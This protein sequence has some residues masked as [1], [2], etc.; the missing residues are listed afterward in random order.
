MRKKLLVLLLCCLGLFGIASGSAVWW[1]SRYLRTPEFRHELAQLVEEATGRT[2]RLDG[3]LSLSFFPWFGLK[4]K[5]FSLGNDPRFG[6]TPLLTASGISARIRVLPLLQRRLVF[7]TVELDNASIVLTMD[8]EGRGNW[9]GLAEHLRKQEDAQEKVGDFFRRITVRGL[10]L[11]DGN[12]RLDDHAHNHSYITTDVDLRTGR[13]ESGKALPFTVSLD[14]YWPRP[15]LTARLNGSGKLHWSAADPGPLLT[16]TAVQAEVGGVFMPKTA[17]RAGLSTVLSVEGGGKHL[18]LSETR[19]RILGYDVEGEI[20]FLDVTEMFHLEA[21]LQLGRFSPRSVLNAYWPGTIAHDYQGALNTASGPLNISADVNKLVFETPGFSL[22]NSQL[23]GFARMGFDNGTGL[24]FDIAANQ[25]DADALISAFT[26]NATSPPLVVAD[27]PLDYLRAVHGAGHIKAESLKLAGVAAQGAQVEWRGA[28][29]VHKAQIKPVKA[30]GGS[31][32]AELSAVFGEGPRDPRLLS[33]AGAPVLGWSGSLSMLGVDARQVSWLNKP[34]LATSGRMDLRA[35][36]EAKPVQAALTATLPH[37]VRRAVADVQVSLASSVLDWSA[38]VTAGKAQ[39]KGASAGQSASQAANQAASSPKR[40]FFS[41]LQAQA[42]FTPA[43]VADADWAL[44]MDAGLSAVGTK[45]LLNLDGRVSGL[46]RGQKGGKVLLTGAN[47]SGRLKG[48]FLPK[49][50]NEASFNGRGALDFSAQTLNLSSASVQ[51]CGVNVG[52]AVNGTKV[53]GADWALAGRLRCQDG[54]PKRVLAALDLRVP[55]AS[56][57]R[58]LQRL[59]GEGDL[60]LSGKGAS[61]ANFS[62]QLDDMPLRG[63]YAVQNFDAP[64]QSVTV[65]GGNF[66]LDRYLPAPEVPKRGAPPTPPTPEALPVDALRDLNL[67]GSVALRSFKYRGVTTRDFRATARAGGGQLLLKPFGGNFY[68]GT[69]TGEFSAQVQGNAMQ[70]RLAVAIKDYQAGPFM[71]GW[72]GKELVTGKADLFLDVTGTGAT[73]LEV[74]RTLEGLGSIKITDGA[75]Y[76]SGAAE[77]PQPQS[78]APQPRRSGAASMQQGQQQSQQPGQAPGPLPGHKPGSPFNLASAKLRVSQG[79]FRSD[80]FRLDA[81]TMAVTGKGRFSPAEDQINVNLAVNMTGMPVV[82]IKVFGRLKD[83]EMEI[84]T[85]TLISNT[86]KSLL[87]I[88]LKPIKFFKDLLF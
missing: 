6:E 33:G 14:F 66:D 72:T 23:K 86:I 57:R 47:A 19:L 67:E 82:P 83:P 65:S 40:M 4:A 75:Y 44:Q 36:A 50:E 79:W 21:K 20:T 68:G 76:L 8:A 25:L 73:D 63:S 30:Q 27:L 28:A 41:S 71:L 51:A 7:D 46:L 87:G 37:V 32:S 3:D 58:V 54:D 35:K 13:I 1:A 53:L 31:A 11:T 60:T 45:P 34:G 42:R 64:R 29:G 62:G 12:I 56:D 88:P 26:S 77:A 9:E 61:L 39:A 24:D 69:L 78:T 74:M 22:D 70:T 15:G 16:E 59:S 48:W 18:K 17:P 49:R 55:K 2:A 43:P 84:S 81:P 5:G 80:D 10:Q 85:G 38:D 52:G